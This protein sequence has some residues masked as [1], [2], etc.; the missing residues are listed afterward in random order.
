MQTQICHTCLRTVK[1]YLV[2][3]EHG[4]PFSSTKILLIWT[5]GRRKSIGMWDISNIPVSNQ[6][7]SLV[8]DVNLTT[9]ASINQN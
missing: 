7:N 4:I 6:Y 2:K 1:I 8:K 9:L 3:E 5:K